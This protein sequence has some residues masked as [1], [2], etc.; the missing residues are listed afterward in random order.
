MGRSYDGDDAGPGGILFLSGRW[1]VDD[2]VGDCSCGRSWWTHGKR[3]L[4]TE[5]KEGVDDE[6]NGGAAEHE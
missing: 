4:R 5:T 3:R 2:R 1:K 6:G